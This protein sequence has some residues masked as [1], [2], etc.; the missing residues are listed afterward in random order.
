MLSQPYL[1][2]LKCF[3]WKIF[4][5]NFLSQHDSILI[6]S[7]LA[8]QFILK[9][10]TLYAM[11][12][13]SWDK[14]HWF[15]VILGSKSKDCEMSSKTQTRQSRSIL[16]DTSHD[17][18]ETAEDDVHVLQ[19][20]VNPSVCL[21]LCLGSQPLVCFSKLKH[22]CVSYWNIR[23][24]LLCHIC[25]RPNGLSHEVTGRNARPL[26]QQE[27]LRAATNT[28]S[29]QPQPSDSRRALEGSRQQETK[30]K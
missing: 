5:Q 13:P 17:S 28:S 25:A 29:L 6:E 12:K 26:T 23:Q 27:A 7:Q 21:C 10:H 14:L 8:F 3:F 11:R 22:E 20:R 15:S 30:D 24:Q 9:S 19:V 18:T 4:A 16:A 2:H 1:Q